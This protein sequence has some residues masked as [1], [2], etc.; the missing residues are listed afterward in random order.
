MIFNKFYYLSVNLIFF[1][2]LQVF[3]L[4]VKSDYKVF[5]PISINNF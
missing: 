2:K 3:F 1:N 4:S 5:A